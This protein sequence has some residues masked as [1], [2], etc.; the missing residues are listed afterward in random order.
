MHKQ[1]IENKNANSCLTIS[2][3]ALT[4]ALNH[5]QPIVANKNALEAL[6][7]T[8]EMAKN[9]KIKDEDITAQ[10]LETKAILKKLM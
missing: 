3:D 2:I 8:K 9:L 4:N 6:E 10:L 7:I 5:D 1:T